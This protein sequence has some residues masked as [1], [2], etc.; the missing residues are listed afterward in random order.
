LEKKCKKFLAGTNFG[1]WV[2]KIFLSE[3]TFEDKLSHL[4]KI[5]KLT[6]VS[7]WGNSSTSTKK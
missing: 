5:H 7:F 1:E 6:K 3:Q 2:K 4:A